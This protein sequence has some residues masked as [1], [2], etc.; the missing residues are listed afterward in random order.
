LLPFFPD[1]VTIDDFKVCIHIF[2]KKM[3]TNSF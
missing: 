2:E 1:F 3:D